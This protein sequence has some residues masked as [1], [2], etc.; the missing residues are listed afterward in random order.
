[1][2]AL[3]LYLFAIIIP[4][5]TVKV[6]YPIWLCLGNQ[7]L[8]RKLLKITVVEVSVFYSY[9]LFKSIK[10]NIKCVLYI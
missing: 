4:I 10:F 6:Y 5:R 8:E 2:S 1:V 3:I 7:L 9:R